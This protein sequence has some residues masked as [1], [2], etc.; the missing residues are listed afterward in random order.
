MTVRLALPYRRGAVGRLRRVI[1]RAGL[2]KIV[3]ARSTEAVLAARGAGPLEMR[4]LVHENILDEG[5]W[6]WMSLQLIRRTPF[7]S[8]LPHLFA[9]SRMMMLGLGRGRRAG[10]GDRRVVG[11]VAHRPIRRSRPS[12]AMR[13]SMS[14]SSTPATGRTRREAIHASRSARRT[15]RSRWPP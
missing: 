8:Q 15:D 11:Q 12:R 13:A 6:A 3:T 1:A 4:K 7:R 2:R 9:C 5:M 10:T 14:R